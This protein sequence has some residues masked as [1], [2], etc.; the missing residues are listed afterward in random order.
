MKIVL[1]AGE[2]SGD[3]LGANLIKAL[4]ARTS[5]LEVLG[6]AGPAMRAAGCRPL[7]DIEQLAV[8]GLAEVIKELPRIWRLRRDLVAKIKTEQPQ[9]IVGIDSPDFNLGIE[10]Q[11]RRAGFCTAHYVSPS[12]WAWRPNRVKKVSKAAHMV[13][14]LFP[15]EPSCYKGQPI[16]A[17]YVGHPL[18]DLIKPQSTSMARERLGINPRALVLALLPG[19]RPGEI[20]RLAPIFFQ[21]AAKLQ[22]ELPELEFIAASASEEGEKQLGDILR[23]MQPSVEVKIFSD[24]THQVIAAAD[25]VLV[26]SGTATL[27]VQLSGRPMVMAYRLSPTT[28]W[29]LRHLRMIRTKRFALPNLICNADVVPELL[30]DKATPENLAKALLPLLMDIPS[31]LR[32]IES[33]QECHTKMEGDAAGHAADALLSLMEKL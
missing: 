25:V 19:S 5:T 12:V 21:T 17:R 2:P 15:F 23:R 7:G 24:Q 30:Q 14:C 8:V 10:V 16:D 3:I 20:S 4:H 18:S 33:F 27:E 31:R 11:L 28:A 9:L 13:L 1:I 26:A 32:Q 22:R 6:I 29:L